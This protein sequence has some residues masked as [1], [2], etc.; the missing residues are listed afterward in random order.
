MAVKIIALGDIHYGSGVCG[1]VER[2]SEI[3]DIF[4]Q[5]LVNRCNRYI[6]P[7]AVVILGDL[8]ENHDIP[9]AAKYL[10]RLAGLIRQFKCPTITI[11][12]NHDGDIETFYK[13]IDKPAEWVDIKNVRLLPFVDP[14]EPHFCAK[15]LPH[16]IARIER[17]RYG[18]HGKIVSLQHVPLFPPGT[19]P[20]GTNYT[21]VGEIIP[22]FRKYGI[23]L[24]LGAHDHAGVELYNHEGIYYGAV[25]GLCESPFGFLEI[26]FDSD[27]ITSKRHKL[28]FPENLKLFDWH[29]HSQFA[30][31]GEDIT[32]SSAL[33]LAQELGLAGIGFAEHSDQLYVSRADWKYGRFFEGGID[34][35]NNGKNN[36]VNDYLDEALKYCR[37]ENV[38]FE[39][40]SDF[41]GR[42]VI[43]RDSTKRAGYLIGSVH[44]VPEQNKPNPSLEKM[45]DE[46]MWIIQKFVT[47][48][49]KILAH[50]FRIFYRAG[51]EQPKKLFSP[52][53]KMLK[54]NNVAAE[55]NFHCN[56]PPPDF[57]KMCIDAGV[58]ITLGTDS[59]ALWEVGE[60]QPHLDLLKNSVA[61]IYL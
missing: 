23:S 18:F 54:E 20:C 49:I 21:N 44:R 14:E 41:Y 32:I 28:K 9:D 29:V 34:A 8:L 26:T 46:F 50:P 39:C 58:Q 36:R 2:R 53:V 59:H 56:E 19:N 25:P 57:F 27:K 37:P 35:I 6:K 43:D 33:A 48:G 1:I 31:C 22:E 11:P 55:I 51:F 47:S 30:Y 12:G 15:R 3:A 16:D 4:L 40:D 45:C 5:K 42:L 61:D 24:S 17:A 7:D 52:V 10:Q 38:G 13:V 60:L